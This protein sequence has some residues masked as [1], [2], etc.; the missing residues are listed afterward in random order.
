MEQKLK[1]Y[2]IA[3][4]VLAIL[5]IILALLL[6]KAKNASVPDSLTQAT[7]NLEKCN[8]DLRAW[9]SANPDPAKA[10]AAAQAELSTILGMCAGTTG[11]ASD[12]DDDNDVTPQ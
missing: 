7:E 12:M 8:A 6:I 3:T 2:E 11:D 9:R 1:N 4:W 5:V 10:T